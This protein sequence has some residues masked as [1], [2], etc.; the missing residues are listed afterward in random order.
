[1][2]KLFIT[3]TAALLLLLCLMLTLFRGQAS[4][5]Q[6]Q[7]SEHQKTAAP[8]GYSPATTTLPSGRK[9][10]MGRGRGFHL[11]AETFVLRAEPEDQ[12]RKTQLVWNRAKDGFYERLL[13]KQ[14]RDKAKEDQLMSRLSGA[15]GEGSDTL[16]GAIACSS[17]FCRVEL[18]G[19]GKVNMQEPRWQQGVLAAVE[20]KGLKFFIVAGD[21]DGNT[22]SSCYFGRDESWTVPDFQALGLM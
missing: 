16:V 11:S 22:I 7:L 5:A 12:T 9:D 8:V 14:G 13:A 19:V 20:P 2:K 21:D 17:Q 15:F 4:V 10:A 6:V 18:Q 1:M 3:V